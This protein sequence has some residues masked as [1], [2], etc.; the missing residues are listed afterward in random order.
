M[1][2]LYFQNWKFQVFSDQ[3]NY[4]TRNKTKLTTLRTKTKYAEKCIHYYL[5]KLIN[6][7]DSIILCNI[8]THSLQGFAHY[9]KTIL[10]ICMNMNVKPPIVMFVPLEFILIGLLTIHDFS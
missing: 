9:V 3:H 10:L 4:N 7:T 1:L 8:Q 5:S 6:D 2:P